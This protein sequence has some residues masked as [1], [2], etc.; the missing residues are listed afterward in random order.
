MLRVPFVTDEVKERYLM[1]K[2][3]DKICT[4]C[5]FIGKCEFGGLQKNGDDKRITVRDVQDLFEVTFCCKYYS[6]KKVK[7][8]KFFLPNK[9]FEKK[10]LEEMAKL[11]EVS[12]VVDGNKVLDETLSWGRLEVDSQK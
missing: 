6:D 11:S 12:I 1:K 9:L 3:A 5:S 10:Y 8:S 7:I 4:G 2:A